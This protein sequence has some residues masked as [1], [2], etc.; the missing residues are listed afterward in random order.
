ML[1]LRLNIEL[2][3]NASF[4]TNIFF[5]SLATFMKHNS[6]I[7]MDIASNFQFNYSELKIYYDSKNSILWGVMVPTN[8]PCF[9]KN[10]LIDLNNWFNEISQN[11]TIPIDY[12]VLAS[13]T[14][15]IY[16]FGGDLELFQKLIKNKDR[17]GLID[18]VCLCIDG[19]DLKMSGFRKNI[20]HICL[21]EG[22]ALGGGFEC[23]LSSDI[24]IAERSAKLGFPEILF[25][26][27]PGMG[28]MS[29]LSRKVGIVTAEYLIKS[30]KLFTAEELHEMKVIDI[31]AEDGK[32]KEAVYEYIRKQK[33]YGNGYKALQK[34]KRL[35]NPISKEELM[36]IGEIWADTALN[37]D[38][39]NLL[40][41]QKIINKQKKYGC[42]NLSLTYKGS[43][44]NEFEFQRI[45]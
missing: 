13:G 29:I 9:S 26:L 19:I 40:M 30:G 2:S 1:P 24:L 34:I 6:K 35:I 37:L 23:A 10:L 25:N 11:T 38:E 31:I 32:G 21:V 36:K 17:G 16:S 28:A 43:S 4:L 3:L 14:K 8:R 27:F 39:K 18:Y 20:N 15:G 41:M 33:R 42:L 7:D 44:F 45:A 12:V 22:D 5:C